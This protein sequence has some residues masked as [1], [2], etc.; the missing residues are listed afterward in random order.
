MDASHLMSV[1]GKCEQASGRRW[2]GW[3][4]PL[5]ALTMVKGLRWSCGVEV[6]Q[7]EVAAIKVSDRARAA[8]AARAI[9]KTAGD[10]LQTRLIRF[11]AL[12]RM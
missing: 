4:L 10:W 3:R 12:R 11:R 6:V 9:D 2:E 5:T 1:A 7:R 8:P